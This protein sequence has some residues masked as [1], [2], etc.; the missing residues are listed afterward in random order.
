MF[1]LKYLSFFFFFYCMRPALNR[2]KFCYLKQFNDLVLTLSSPRRVSASAGNTARRVRRNTRVCRV[3]LTPSSAPASIDTKGLSSTLSSATVRGLKASP[4]SR[5]KRACANVS[6]A[7][8]SF[9]R[10]EKAAAS[11]ASPECSHRTR[12]PSSPPASHLHGK[13]GRGST[14]HRYLGPG[15]M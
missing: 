2:L 12:N 10:L 9:A 3:L 4:N 13:M 15:G 5:V 8:G 1:E 14:G 11:G 7:R 6:S